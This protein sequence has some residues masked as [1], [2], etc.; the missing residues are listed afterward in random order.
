[1]SQA[2]DGRN[3]E[4]QYLNPEEQSSSE[5]RSESA[6]DLAETRLRHGTRHV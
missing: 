5:M 3:Q 4:E 1:M 6:V 2:E